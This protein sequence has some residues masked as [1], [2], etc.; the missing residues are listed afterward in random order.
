MM[1]FLGARLDRNGLVLVNVRLDGYPA[2]FHVEPEAI[3]RFLNEVP[4]HP[5]HAAT[6]VE[7]AWP[8]FAG[9]FETLVRRHGQDF[10]V[11]EAMLLRK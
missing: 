7:E 4:A 3:A 8:R 5:S 9:V 6:S 1:T 10:I 2:Y 11:D